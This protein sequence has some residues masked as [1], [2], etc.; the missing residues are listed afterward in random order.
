MATVAL[1]FSAPFILLILG[2][3]LAEMFGKKS[4]WSTK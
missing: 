2:T 3:I 1:A 4:R